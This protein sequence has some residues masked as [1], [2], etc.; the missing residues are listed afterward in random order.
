MTRTLIGGLLGGLALYLIGFLF[1]GT[2]LS[3]IPF[4]KVDEARSAAVQTALAQN[5]SQNGT[6]T[7]VVPDPSTQSGTTLFGQGPIATVHFNTGG[8]PVV[9][10]SALISGLVL[11]LVTGVLMAFALATIGGRVTAFA[12]RAR[13]VILLALSFTVWIHLGQPI[14]N[15]HGWLYFSYLF[16]TDLIGLSACGLVIVRW[17][18]PR[19]AVPSA[20]QV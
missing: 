13:V 16:V 12:D 14:F 18:L 11:A 4:S 5:L 3:A 7:Y 8:F 15:H 1:W 6:G 20:Q 17:F 19:E 9:D 2:P 10:S